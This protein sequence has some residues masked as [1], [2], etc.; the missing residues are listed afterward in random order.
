MDA[1]TLNMTRPSVAH[2]YV[3]VDLT[4]E[5]P[6]SVKVE[7]KKGKKNDQLFTYEHVPDYCSNCSK[8]GYRKEEC[9]AGILKPM[10]KK[11]KAPAQKTQV[12]SKGNLANNGGDVKSQGGALRSNTPS[13][14]VEN[15]KAAEGLSLKGVTDSDALTLGLSRREKE[16][17][18]V[19]V[20]ATVQGKSDGS[21]KTAVAATLP[22]T[23]NVATGN[24]NSTGSNRFSVLASIL[25][26]DDEIS[27]DDDNV[28]TV[29]VEESPTRTTDD[30][31]QVLVLFENPKKL[32]LLTDDNSV[33]EKEEA[34]KRRKR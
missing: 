32:S 20:P 29:Y 18:P 28:E 5:L 14:L 27:S 6:K 17:I 12:Q 11:N 22:E 31:N 16:A 30:L 34:V 4:K 26:I 23:L 9:H 13:Q 7:E 10:E 2:F 19:D 1:P 3:E 25:E 21:S 15:P 8:I 33:G 24:P